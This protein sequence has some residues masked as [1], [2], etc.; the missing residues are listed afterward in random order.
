MKSKAKRTL[1]FCLLNTVSLEGLWDG[2]TLSFELGGR[3]NLC[4]RLQLS[5]KGSACNTLGS[6]HVCSVSQRKRAALLP[7][8][9]PWLI[10]RQ[11]LLGLWVLPGHQAGSLPSPSHV[12]L[13]GG[14][15]KLL[16]S[17][18]RTLGIQRGKM[19]ALPEAAFTGLIFPYGQKECL[20]VCKQL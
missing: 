10:Q 16:E 18:L 7:S 9:L 1:L 2:I 20:Q 17:C 6:S 3:R 19:T 12:L 4:F 5:S 14:R 8:C 15:R 13:E 11:H